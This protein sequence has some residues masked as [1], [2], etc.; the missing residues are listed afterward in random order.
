MLGIVRQNDLFV[1]ANVVKDS[2]FVTEFDFPSEKTF[3]LIK[4]LEDRKFVWFSPRN[5]QMEP[6][7]K[8]FRFLP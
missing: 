8:D 2:Y 5:S 4:F 3:A 6:Q 7:T 1:V